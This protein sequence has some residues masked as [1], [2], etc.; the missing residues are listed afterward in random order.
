MFDTPTRALAWTLTAALLASLAPAGGLA[1]TGNQQN[2]DAHEPIRIL[3][4]KGD[5][6]FVWDDPVTGEEV[7]RPDSGVV[8]GDGSAS[9]PYVI[10]GWCI[11]GADWDPPNIELKEC[12]F[13]VGD[14]T[15]DPES[16]GVV[17]CGTSDRFVFQN[18]TVN[19]WEH[20]TGIGNVST[21]TGA[22]DH[23]D[24][25]NNTHQVYVDEAPGLEIRHNLVHGVDTTEMIRIAER[26]IHAVSDDLVI[27]GNEFV[28]ASTLLELEGD[29]TRVADNR[30]DSGGMFAIDARGQGLGVVD[31]AI[32]TTVFDDPAR[33]AIWVGGDEA[34][35]EE[36]TVDGFR[37][38]GILLRSGIGLEAGHNAVTSTSDGTG[39]SVTAETARV[40]NTTVEGG[41]TGVGT[42][43]G[44]NGVTIENVT[45]DGADV[46]LDAY[47]GNDTTWRSNDVTNYTDAGLHVDQAENVTLRQTNFADT[48]GIGL[49]I[50]NTDTTVDARHNWWGCAD[51]PDDPACDDVVGDAVYDPW[52][53]EENAEAGAA[54]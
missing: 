48:G 8:A 2:C 27:E 7:Y 39:V 1:A 21:D 6:G 53:V 30:L 36:N 13:D 34:L 49:E 37:S 43:A 47:K 33:Y 10:E 52:L 44:T 50:E 46:G 40:H 28:G 11:S 18:N 35:V 9:N 54:G 31:N 15:P 14:A 41:W 17:I 12:G 26:G 20:G 42:G 22:I 38:V 3:E 24:H 4:D 45:V 23:T 32:E 16:T 51:G 5:D 25:R 19:L 29:G